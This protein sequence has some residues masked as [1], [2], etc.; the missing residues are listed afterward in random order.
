MLD[1][2]RVVVTTVS[3]LQEVTAVPVI[4]YPYAIALLPNPPVTV[5]AET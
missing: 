5:V 1:L 2:K 3:E 4:A